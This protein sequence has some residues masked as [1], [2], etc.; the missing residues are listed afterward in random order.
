MAFL[1]FFT[2]LLISLLAF[3]LELGLKS[4]HYR[5]DFYSHYLMCLNEKSWGSYKNTPLSA[6]VSRGFLLFKLHL[7]SNFS[8]SCF[9]TNSLPELS[10]M[11]FFLPRQL[12]IFENSPPTRLVVELLLISFLFYLKAAYLFF[13]MKF[14]IGF[15]LF[16]CSNIGSLNFNF[17]S[18]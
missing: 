9:E 13:C 17:L 4:R 10:S 7:V 6:L 1:E 8:A 3:A 12:Y 11:I 14:K 5:P 15:V 18:P 2:M 16:C